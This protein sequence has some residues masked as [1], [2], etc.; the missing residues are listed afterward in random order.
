MPSILQALIETEVLAVNNS[1][2]SRHL[3]RKERKGERNWCFHPVYKNNDTPG[4]WGLQYGGASLFT[5]KTSC[6]ALS[7]PPLSHKCES[8]T[9]RSQCGAAA[10]EQCSRHVDGDRNGEQTGG[11]MQQMTRGVNHCGEDCFLTE[12]CSLVGFRH[13]QWK[14]VSSSRDWLLIW[15]SGYKCRN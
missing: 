11:R 13:K 8:V 7:L 12:L 14:E 15:I 6:R 3:E 10:G 9:M 1:L 2:F 5:V 4:G